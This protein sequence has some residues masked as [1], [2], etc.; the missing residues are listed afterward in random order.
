MDER[1]RLDEY[2]T[3]AYRRDVLHESVEVTMPDISP[4]LIDREIDRIDGLKLTAHLA[5]RDFAS[6]QHRR[7][8]VA[9][10]E[11]LNAS[12]VRDERRSSQREHPNPDGGDRKKPARSI[13]GTGAGD[14]IC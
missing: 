8:L 1:K 5:N 6:Y 10:K 4:E 3:Q 13:E 9:L 14:S 12:V 2:L 7:A 11:M